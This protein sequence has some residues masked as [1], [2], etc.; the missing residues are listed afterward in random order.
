LVATSEAKA[1]TAYTSKKRPLEPKSIDMLQIE[2][3]SV[4]GDKSRCTDRVTFLAPAAADSVDGVLDANE[5]C[6][7][8]SVLTSPTSLHAFL[9]RPPLFTR[10]CFTR[11][12]SRVLASPAT[13]HAFM[14]RPPP[15][16]RS[17][18]ARHPSRVLASPAT[19][20]AFMLRP[21][22]FTRFCFARHSSRFFA[23]PATLHAFL[24]RPPPFTHSCFASTLHLLLLSRSRLRS[25]MT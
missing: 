5:V 18:F 23:S 20:H 4:H 2:R 9:L 12:S 3:P 19:L 15:F 1:S 11:H 24:L 17:C 6:H 8:S 14:L 7:S 22:L 25:A 13:L 10:S 21:P 16:T